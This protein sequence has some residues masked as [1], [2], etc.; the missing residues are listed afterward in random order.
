VD[1]T[2]LYQTQISLT[3]WLA[4]M[5]HEKADALRKEDNLKRQRI[6]YLHK[7]IR[8]PFDETKQFPAVELDPPSAAVQAFI[9]AKGSELCALRLTPKRDELPKLRMR[10][11][12]V[13]DALVWFK[14]Q[15]INPVEY[16]AEFVPHAP[17][18]LWSSIFVVNKEGIF[19]EVIAGGHHQLTQGFYEN[20]KPIQ[21]SFDFH[22]LQLSVP[23]AS[24]E[25]HIRDIMSKVHV[26]KQLQEQIRIDMQATFAHDYLCGYF[27]TV[28]SQER[29]LDFIDYNRLLGDLYH[30]FTVQHQHH[31]GIVTG[32]TASTG[33]AKG[34]VRI[35]PREALSTAPFTVG[36]ILVCAMTSPEYLPLMQKASAV[37]TDLGGV[38]SHAAVTC[39][40]LKKP[41][42]VGTQNA[43]K[44]LHDGMVVIVDADKGT[45]DELDHS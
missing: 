38:L 9:D 43:T 30:G 14:E 27:E 21:F 40:E 2:K 42:I 20:D 31:K 16:N 17:T 11:H 39:R 7:T 22:T 5:Q 4:A 36:D 12:T 26:P 15:K 3:E 10:G 8:L 29:G 32:Y 33:K 44:A 19:G 6:Q 25:K 1:I 24:A 35:V 13:R 37:V 34:T 23:N 41:C 18:S 28:L 45:V